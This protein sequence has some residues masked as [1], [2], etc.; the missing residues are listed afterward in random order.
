MGGLLGGLRA[1]GAR[2]VP[3]RV[4]AAWAAGSSQRGGSWQRQGPHFEFSGASRHALVQLVVDRVGNSYERAAIEKWLERTRTSPV[5]RR[6]LNADDLV[7]NRALSN[8]IEAAVAARA[9]S[10][11]AASGP[12]GSLVPAVGGLLVSGLSFA[13]QK[14]V[15]A[16]AFVDDQ[17]AESSCRRL[18]RE[19][20]ARFAAERRADRAVAPPVQP[21]PEAQVRQ[22]RL[23]FGDEDIGEPSIQCIASSRCRLG[24]TTI[25]EHMANARSAGAVRAGSSSGG[26]GSRAPAYQQP[27]SCAA[28]PEDAG[29]SAVAEAVGETLSLSKLMWETACSEI[30]S[31]LSKATSAD[32]EIGAGDFLKHLMS[33]SMAQADVIGRVHLD[34][35]AVNAPLVRARQRLAWASALHPRLGA[36]NLPWLR[37]FTPACARRIGI[38]VGTEIVHCRVSHS[39]AGWGVRITDGATI[40]Y[41]AIGTPAHLAGLQVGDTILQIGAEGSQTDIGSSN[42]VVHAI[43]ALTAAATGTASDGTPG[44]QEF[45][46]AV[47]RPVLPKPSDMKTSLMMIKTEQQAGER[48][49]RAWATSWRPPLPGTLRNEASGMVALNSQDVDDLGRWAESLRDFSRLCKQQGSVVLL[50]PTAAGSATQPLM[51][52]DAALCAAFEATSEQETMRSGVSAGNSG[53]PSWHPSMDDADA[54][55]T[56]LQKV[57]R[58]W[59]QQC[60]VTP[61]PEAEEMTRIS[62]LIVFNL[63]VK[64]AME[65][66]VA[67]KVF[68]PAMYQPRF[69]LGCSGGSYSGRPAT[70]RVFTYGFVGTPVLGDRPDTKATPYLLRLCSSNLLANAQQPVAVPHQLYCVHYTCHVTAAKR[71]ATAVTADVSSWLTESLDMN[72]ADSWAWP[73]AIPYLATDTLSSE[74]FTITSRPQVA[75]Q[76]LQAPPVLRDDSNR[77]SVPAARS[78]PPPIARPRAA[79]ATRTTMPTMGLNRA[80]VE[81]ELRLELGQGYGMDIS[82]TAQVTAFRRSP[83]GKAS[84]A[85]RAGVEIGSIITHVDGLPVATDRDIVA[86]LRNP[87]VARQGRCVFTFAPPHKQALE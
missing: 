55:F 4:S 60:D 77:L 12:Q 48:F 83:S 11:M 78:A 61:P 20:A 75:Q 81:M 45:L 51:A 33:S 13:K 30:G 19:H 37:A 22:V 6:P 18:E 52:L 66:C 85:E 71:A 1:A 35:N 68:P 24:C 87:D 25:A 32:S 50:C 69:L 9:A 8:V 70:L 43:R 10:G 47:T 36:A 54:C 57:I 64:P 67:C 29:D 34:G 7:P 59:F 53:S 14:T 86:H 38:G 63:T 58:E 39:S 80:V 15:Q 56:A 84:V 31:A 5:T 40:S 26:S 73:P 3:V 62:R 65:V 21:S 23:P 74:T 2:T 42:E 49:A 27:P 28:A 17:R 82:T 76:E 46:V 41:T 44:P 16:A 79:V 72:D